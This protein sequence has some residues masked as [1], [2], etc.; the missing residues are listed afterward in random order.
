MKAGLNE[1]EPAR[2]ARWEKDDLYNRILSRRNPDKKYILHDGPPYANGNIHLGT[3]LNKILKDFVVKVKSGQGFYSP[4]VPGWDCHGLP[5]EH[6]VDKELGDKKLALTK[7]DIRK[8]C[9][10]YA[11]KW[12]DVQRQSFKRLGVIGD[13]DNPYITMDYVYESIT[14]K[15]FYRVYKAG[16]V[17]KGAKPVYWCS[18]CV[19]ALAEAEV[20]YASHT[21]FSIFVKFPLEEGSASKLGITEPVS[22]VIWTTTPWTLPANM[23]ISANPAE[24]YSVM[25]VDKVQDDAQ[26]GNLKEG[27]L[28]LVAAPRWSLVKSISGDSLEHLQTKHPFYDRTSMIILGDHV[29]MTDG[30]GLVHTAPAH[31]LEDYAVGN[32]YGIEVYNPV[33]DYGKFREDLPLFGGMDINKANK[34]IIDLMQDNGTLIAWGKMEHSYPHCWRCK[35]PVIYRSTPQWFISMEVNGLREKALDAVYNKVKFIPSWGSN[36]IGSMVENRPD[37]CISRQRVWGVPIALFTCRKCEGVIFNEEMEKK[38]ID[39][40]VK[41]GADAWFEHDVEYYLGKDAKCPHCGSGDIRQETDI[42]DVWFDSGTSHAA[43]C[44]ARPELGEADMYLEGSDQHRGWFQ[45]SLLESIAT[46]GKAPFKEILTHGF[47]VDADMK[48]MSKSVGNV[49]LPEEIIAKHGAEIMR[50]WVASEDYTDDIRISDEI[51]KRQVESYRKIRNTMRYLLGNL[52]DF[53]P[54]EDSVPFAEMMDLDRY[55]LLKLDETLNKIYAGYEDYQFHA[56]LPCFYEFL[57]NRSISSVFR[58]I[59]RQALFV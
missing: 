19:T 23:A 36:R 53:N 58:Y 32:K 42:L 37:W 48:K 24:E 25:R 49:V 3:A 51:I 14:L 12:L 35:E 47:L 10:E 38:V 55:I 57:H 31:G 33:D 15:E 13:W 40:F 34:K 1:Q 7:N 17:Y 18:S 41:M 9:R 30:T 21:S 4:Y 54:D 56:F 11:A 20:E 5:I 44:E 8:L 52:Y 6:K 26:A 28:L 59:K 45:S 2:L 29:L 27:E 50:L 46:R 16:E 43:V 22:A 39:S